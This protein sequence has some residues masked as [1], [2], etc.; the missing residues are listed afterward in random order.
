VVLP[1]K[2][3]SKIEL[4]ATLMARYLA[5]H[6]VASGASQRVLVMLQYIRGQRDPIAFSIDA[7]NPG[8]ADARIEEAVRGIF[9]LTPWGMI[10][11]LGLQKDLYAPA[12]SYGYFGNPTREFPWERENAERIAALRSALT[13][14]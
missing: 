2:D 13:I 6:L 9:N 5:R 8:I 7:G 4:T 14:N 1:G 12:A 11:E 10:T 3:P